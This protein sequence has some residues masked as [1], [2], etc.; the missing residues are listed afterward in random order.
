[1][2][3]LFLLL[4]FLF[5][6]FANDACKKG[7]ISGYWLS[8]RDSKSGRSSLIKIFK[9][10]G[11]Y[12]GYIMIFM[13]TLD[14]GNDVK[15]EDFALRDRNILGSVYIYNLKRSS[16]YSY[17]NGKYYDFNTGKTFHLSTS[18][19]CNYLNLLISVDNTGF[20]GERRVY[21]YIPNEDAEFYLKKNKINA[22]FSGVKNK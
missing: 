22:D 5:N 21:K 19:S 2:R 20:F 18:L 6:A 14:V 1:M 4:I 7:D 3:F 13:D 9:N 16:D 12:F 17:I 15:N 8:D 10:N 11:K